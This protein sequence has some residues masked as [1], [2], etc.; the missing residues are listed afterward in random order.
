MSKLNGSGNARRIW[1]ILPVVSSDSLVPMV[2]QAEA[3]GVEGVFAYQ[4]Y[5]PPFIPLATA[6]GVTKTLRLASGIAIAGTRSPFETAMAAR[7]LDTIS[8]GRFTLGLGSSIPAWTS[9]VY[10]GPNI[11]PLA[12]LRETVDVIRYI[13]GNAHKGL[14]AYEGTYYKAD[15]DAFRGVLAPPIKSHMPIWLAAMREKLTRMAVEIG[16]GVIGHPMWSVE[17][18]LNEMKPAIED[19][20]QKRNKNRADIEISIW[21][22]AAPNP[23]EQEALDDARP[24]VA[25]YA[26]VEPY[27]IVFEKQG[28]LEEARALQA[29]VAEEGFLAASRLV[30]DEMVRA[31]VAVGDPDK[32]RERIEPVWQLA[33]SICVSPPIYTLTPEKLQYYSDMI[34]STFPPGSL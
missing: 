5:G 31:F 33:D 23:N 27:E 3:D 24:T 20:L 25:F 1:R 2:R 26:G 19:E 28:F 34:A 21:P 12:H 4:V 22:F 18:A 11:K 16:D 9:G 17:W 7:D 13:H 6:A 14:D 15:F 32:V 8:D 10:G 30:P 29:A